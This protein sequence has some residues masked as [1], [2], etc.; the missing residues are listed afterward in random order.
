MAVG[1][2]NFLKDVLPDDAEIFKKSGDLF[3]KMNNVDEAE[4][5][6]LEAVEINPEY[7]DAY[8]SLGIVYQ[9]LKETE[10][11]VKMFDEALDIDPNNYKALNNKGFL[12]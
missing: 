11:A 2:F 7:S 8:V 3:M 9:S 4:K 1:C 10:K 5:N 12:E 6:Y